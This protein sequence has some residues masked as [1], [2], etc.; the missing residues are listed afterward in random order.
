MAPWTILQIGLA[1]IFGKML[2][3]TVSD[4]A[5]PIPIA[6]PDPVGLLFSGGPASWHV[7]TVYKHSQPSSLVKYFGLNSMYSQSK[8]SINGLRPPPILVDS[9]GV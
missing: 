3:K 4:S 9:A 5:A 1:D 6:C 2:C 7:L 8:R